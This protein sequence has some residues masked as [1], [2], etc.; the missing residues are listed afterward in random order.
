MATSFDDFCNRKPKRA[1][2]NVAISFLDGIR[3]GQPLR[4][5]RATLLSLLSIC[6]DPHQR[7][8]LTTQGMAKTIIDAIL[9][10]TL[11]DSPSNLAAATLFYILTSDGQD[12]HLL[13]SPGC[14][15]FLIKLLKPCVSK[16]S[17]AKES[18]FGFKLLASNKNASIYKNTKERMD[19]SSVAIFSRVQEIL[20]NCKELESTSP[21][22]NGV[23]RPELCPKWIALLTIEKACLR[24][25][26]LDDG[27]GLCSERSGTVRNTGGKFKEKLRVLGV[28]NAVFEIAMS[29][30]SDLEC[31]MEDS[32]LSTKDVR[33]DKLP[34]ILTLLLKCLKIIENAAF[35]S[36]D[37]QT[38]LLGLKGKPSPLAIPLSFVELVIT[39]IKILHDL[40][41]RW[42]PSA[43][44]NDNKPDDPFPMGSQCSESD[45]FADHNENETGMYYDMER[46]SPVRSLNLPQKS[47]L[48]TST[49]MSYEHTN[50]RVVCS[51]SRSYS[52]ASR[53]SDDSHDPFE[54]DKVDIAPSEWDLL[55]R[56]PKKS[57]FK[58]ID[59][60]NREFEAGCKSQTNVRRQ[61]SSND[62]HSSLVTGCLL[63]SVKVLINLTNENSV[64]CQQ[65]AA[66]GGLETMP[67][68]IVDH[69]PSK[70]GDAK[71]HHHDRNLT[72]HE[73]DFLVAILGLLVNLVE[74][75]G[76][77][78]SR[79]A[80]ASVPLA[81]SEGLCQEF[82][83][84]V[85]Q[86]LCSIF[87]DNHGVGEDADK[88][89]H[90]LMI[91]SDVMNDA[92]QNDEA[93][94]RQ[95]E[96]EAGKMIVEAYS[97]LLLAFLSTE[98]KSIREAIAEN[99]PQHNLSMLVPVLDRFV[100]C[101]VTID[102]DCFCYI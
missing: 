11:N 92:L 74:K 20:V 75:D 55:S 57:C 73:L 12:V 63:T 95:G 97:A 79:L 61:E 27:G 13:E 19:S 32:S 45:Q 83:M 18:T 82:R 7:H 99:L 9:G 94:F 15:R 101:N 33:N 40:C 80:A 31:W 49:S 90:M 5:I 25:I 84:G 56:N 71:D 22:G 30:L 10:L 89:E 48:T 36:K 59:V 3:K 54:F 47:Q 34:K 16:A 29:C 64:G 50:A 65:V 52:A 51:L 85:I 86:L 78:R 38:H 88:D 62:E 24:A 67:L 44:S 93:A 21:N 77:N 8:F 39:V 100:V 42:S 76:T 28:L 14:I 4:I 96:K 41:S 6:S 69:F 2:N 91:S 98:S 58:K 72:D 43:L 81:A 102:D 35:L 23:E 37:N 70:I 26:S 1:K 66:Y 53:C 87:L 46:A 60:A 17:E 68:L